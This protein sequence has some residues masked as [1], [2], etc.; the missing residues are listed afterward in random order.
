MYDG[1]LFDNL[2]E[3]L[4]NQGVILTPKSSE[5]IWQIIQNAAE[6]EVESFFTLFETFIVLM[7]SNNYSK[8]D[9]VNKNFSTEDISQKIRNQKFL[10]IIFP[11]YQKYQ[12]YLKSR[13]EIDFS[14]M[15][16]RATY[17]I[18]NGK[19]K[20]E[21]KYII[22]D[23]FQDISIG[24]YKLIESLKIANPEC[25]LFCVGD[26]WQSIYRFTGSDI[27]LF[28]E[29]EKYFGFTV[30][31]KIETTYRFHNPLIKLS[32][33]F[34]TKN[35]NQA[36]K[37][38]KSKDFLQKTSFNF[39]YSNAENQDDT[40]ALKQVFDDLPNNLEGKEILILGRYSFDIERI[41]NKLGISLFIREQESNNNKIINEYF[42]SKGKWKNLKINEKIIIKY[43]GLE[44]EFLT[45]HKA[46]GLEADIVI[47]LNCN[48]G[49]FGFPSQM[50]DDPILNLLL[51]E[52]DQFENGEERRVFY[53]AMTRAKEKV[54]FIADNSYKSKFIAELEVN[55][56]IS[57][58][59]KC[60]HCV[61]ADL[62]KRSGS[63][64][65]KE[66]AFYGCSNFLYGCDYKEWINQNN[67]ISV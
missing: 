29:F 64:N 59:K 47:V 28:K 43:S 40:L 1:T 26:D 3:R 24:R 41:A 18:S 25:K 54:Y 27:A 61:T 46:K 52:A 57:E 56:G 62:I 45:V 19:Y 48:S 38:L 11:I 33:D 8:A 23:E 55:S 42:Y 9:L 17:Y 63:K 50:S 15:I 31:S 2:T 4:E 30:K 65:G 14:D 12:D 37:E 58:I 16:N 53:V 21:I 36:R 13:G 5:E 51:S 10:E 20:K 66:W 39:V 6:E 22:I 35:P 49:K 7:K 60:P 67:T 34:I 44:A 32:S